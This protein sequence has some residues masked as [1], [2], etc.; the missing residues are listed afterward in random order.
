MPFICK[1]QKIKSTTR[2]L[3]LRYISILTNFL[4]TVIAQWLER[5][6]GKHEVVDS[7]PTWVNFLYGI[8]KP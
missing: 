7:N 6:Y 4:R 2:R 1:C 5:V 8:E 3:N